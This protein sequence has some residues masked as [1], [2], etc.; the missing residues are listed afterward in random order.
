MSSMEWVRR[1]IKLTNGMAIR[2]VYTKSDNWSISVNHNNC[3][4]LITT[5][6]LKD[7]WVSKGLIENSFFI[8]YIVGE[9][10]YS[11]FTGRSGYLISSMEHG[12]YPYSKSQAQIFAMALNEIR[13]YDMQ[14]SLY[15]SIFL[16]QIPI[17]LPTYSD[18]EKLSDARV[19]GTWISAG[20]KLDVFAD[21]DRIDSL[22]N[23]MS[24]SDI[25]E[26]IK[27]A[28]LESTG[29]FSD[30]KK[31]ED[32]GTNGNKKKDISDNN[33]GDVNK[34]FSLPGRPKLEAF[35]NEHVL[36]VINNQDE[37]KRMGIE[38]PAAI[39]LHGPPGCGK[40]YAVE[41]LV[42]HLKWPKY[43]IDS[44]SIGSPYI[45]GTGK[46]IAETFDIAIQNAPS[47]III[48][49]MEAFLTDRNAQSSGLHHI[50]EVAE[51]LRRIPEATR[52]RVLVIAMT[53]MIDSIDQAILRKGRFDHV[54]SVEMASVEE[55]IAALESMLVNL[56]VDNNV[57]LEEI[58]KVLKG[59]PL[60]DV[61]YVV[62]EA[63]R[64]AVKRKLKSIDNSV[65]MEACS[66]LEPI[67]QSVKRIGFNFENNQTER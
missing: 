24:R 29:N 33:Y 53:N 49:E 9:S 66:Y 41:K 6:S 32:V 34:S 50:E 8:D 38:F 42:E 31:N 2:K 10:I 55:I 16:E 5:E 15:D 28:G 17:I 14:D 46:K 54:I 18:I 39:V 67:E 56:P 62:K 63:G 13:N 1:G 57:N 12:P 20:V 27:E 7:K 21:I 60:S 25:K 4:V 40:T 61:S 36:D 64:I 52:N 26:I 45:H 3:F 43:Q 19:L 58:S 51:F 65:L 47:V 11:I 44:A 35:F 22:T 59:R 23:W 37:Y 30:L 48:D